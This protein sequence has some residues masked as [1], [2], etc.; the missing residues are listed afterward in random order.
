MSRTRSFFGG[1]F[2]AY[3]YQGAAMLVGLWL[4]PFYI[5]VL[6]QHDYGVWLVGLQ[7][8]TFL[9]L[10]DFGILA[11]TPRDVAHAS[12]KERSEP[13]SD[14]LLVLVGQTMKVVLAQ[15]VLIAVVAV[16]LY[17]FRP[18]A[19]GLKGPIGMLLAVFVLSY[20][21]RLFPAVL[22]GLQ[23]LKF[24]GQLR[25]WLWG[26]STALG[27]VLLLLGA[28]FYALACGWCVHEVS[29][30]LI[31][32]FR[33]HRI[34]P[35]LLT[36]Q[37]WKKAGPLRWRW[38]TRGSWV[39]VGQ[40]G[41]SFIAGSDLIITER[42]LGAAMVVIYSS[43][44]KLVTVLQNQPQMLAAFA[45]PGLS[46]MK[47]SESRERILQ[48]TVSLTQAMLLLV[49]AV[50]C[51]ILTVNQQFVSLWLGP[52]FFGGMRLTILFLL[53]FVVRQMDYTLA[54]ALFAFG[55]EKL[56]ALR[57]LFDG[58]VSAVLATILGAHFGFEGIAAGF[59]CGSL[60]VSIPM[61]A[62]LFVREFQ[63]SVGEIVAPYVAYLWR[64]AVIGVLGLGLK[65]WIGSTTF[66][67]AAIVA[68]ATLGLYLLLVLPHVW[69]TPLRG[70][71]QRVAAALGSS[72]R[73]RIPGLAE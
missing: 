33:L 12:G 34:R 3:L 61:D 36:L 25:I 71:I 45:L 52:Q 42:A 57:S 8:L 21:L 18:T 49:G 70:Y 66:A 27:V 55:H 67:S 11:A 63:L 31:A 19:P 72:M 1:A 68:V 29:N 30:N 50:S 22:N 58:A 37:V 15:T 53:I 38:F 43:T 47:T 7:V 20:P 4:T 73:S 5:R 16:V 65:A 39:N 56:L 6:G 17:A 2:F 51:V 60:L 48:A 32:L 69:R 46:Q 9:L 40:I 64:F 41:Y 44:S 13:A 54:I 28:R 10:C 23:D 26:L 62:F 24:L 59:L 14:E 35:D